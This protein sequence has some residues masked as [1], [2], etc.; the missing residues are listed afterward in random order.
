MVHNNNEM[1]LVR[2]GNAEP[3]S[4]DNLTRL[5]GRTVVGSK[6]N[7]IG[8]VTDLYIDSIELIPRCLQVVLQGMRKEKWMVL[9]PLTTIEIVTAYS[10]QLN[11]SRDQ[12]LTMPKITGGTAQQWFLQWNFRQTMTA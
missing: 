4:L 1:S 2:L 6:G 12:I 10:I 9:I 5:R 8:T 11:K 3:E 7:K